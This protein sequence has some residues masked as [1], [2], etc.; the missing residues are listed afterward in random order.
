MTRMARHSALAAEFGRSDCS[1]REAP[2]VT[3]VVVRQPE[4]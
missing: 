4:F 3:V 2:I 1:C